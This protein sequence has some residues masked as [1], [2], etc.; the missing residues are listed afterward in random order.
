MP[1]KSRPYWTAR[2]IG[3][4]LGMKPHAVAVYLKADPTAPKPVVSDMRPD[5]GAQMY[6]YHEHEARAWIEKFEK[7]RNDFGG[8]GQPTI[9]LDDPTMR[10]V[11]YLM[12]ELGWNSPKIAPLVGVSTFVLCNAVRRRTGKTVYQLRRERQEAP[13]PIWTDVGVSTPPRKIKSRPRRPDVAHNAGS[14]A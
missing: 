8:L 13:G 1:K 6:G 11:L 10:K 2:E 4:E 7:S 12:I 5:G 9:T 3:R 14:T